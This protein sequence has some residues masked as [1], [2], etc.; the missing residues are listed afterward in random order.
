MWL[1]GGCGD[2]CV[3]FDVRSVSCVCVVVADMEG[4]AMGWVGWCAWGRGWWVCVCVAGRGVVGIGRCVVVC[5]N[6]MGGVY[7]FLV[8]CV[9]WPCEGVPVISQFSVSF[10]AVDLSM[11]CVLWLCAGRYRKVMC[12]SV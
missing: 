8:R 9:A 4:G 2:G 5:G 12:A 3:G 7:V 6:G 1:K 11:L 10:T